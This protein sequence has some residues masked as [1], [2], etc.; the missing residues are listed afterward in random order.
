MIEGKTRQGEN[1]YLMPLLERSV[2][3]REFKKNSKDDSRTGKYHGK[4]E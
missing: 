3:T 1:D 4:Q 2:E